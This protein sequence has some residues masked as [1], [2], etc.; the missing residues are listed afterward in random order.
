MFLGRA[1]TGLHLDLR[2]LFSQQ[3]GAQGKFFACVSCSGW[4][5]LLFAPLT[6]LIGL[7]LGSGAHIALTG[8]HLD[9]HALC[10]QQVRP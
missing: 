4:L 7:I 8:L 9:L 5:G 10:F 6:V 1:L 3:V 2:D